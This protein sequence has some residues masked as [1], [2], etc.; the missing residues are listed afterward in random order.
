M[1]GLADFPCEGASG[2]ARWPVRTPPGS[3][4][5]SACRTRNRPD[6]I[7]PRRT[8]MRFNTLCPCLG[9]SLMVLIAGGC[10]G[11]FVTVKGSGIAR[12]E[13]R[14]VHD[15]SEM[16]LSGSGEVFI[17]QTGKESLTIEADDNLLPYLETEV[18][19]GALTLGTVR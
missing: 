15:F 4:L 8:A 12:Q 5:C 9:L 19:G 3:L 13:S 6:R 11:D 1:A 14:Q 10:V 7:D 18:Q 17:E 2:P 16:S